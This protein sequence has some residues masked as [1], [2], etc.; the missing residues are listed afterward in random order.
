MKSLFLL[1]KT[2]PEFAAQYPEVND[3]LDLTL[4]AITDPDKKKTIR[5]LTEANAIDF[6]EIIITDNEQQNIVEVNADKI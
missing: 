4:K 6:E 2:N 5:N 1:R 3:Y